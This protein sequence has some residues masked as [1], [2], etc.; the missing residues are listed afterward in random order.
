MAVGTEVRPIGHLTLGGRGFILQV[1][2]GCRRDGILLSMVRER[3]LN[4]KGIAGSDRPVESTCLEFNML[5]SHEFAG[6]DTRL[7]FETGRPIF[8]DVTEKTGL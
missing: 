8:L 4:G 1:P 6:A 5:F 2:V 3:R 7:P